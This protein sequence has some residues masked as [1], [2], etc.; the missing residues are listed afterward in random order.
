MT[1]SSSTD[2]MIGDL[3][4]HWKQFCTE[5]GE[6]RGHGVS[7]AA[8]DGLHNLARRAHLLDDTSAFAGIRVR[9]GANRIWRRRPR[10]VGAGRRGGR[11]A[12]SVHLFALSLVEEKRQMFAEGD[13]GP[14]GNFAI[15][16]ELDTVIEG[17]LCH[18]DCVDSV[19]I[20]DAG[21]DACMAKIWNSCTNSR[22]CE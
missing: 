21:V 4:E 1:I 8:I 13:V 3:D 12:L 17:L 16:R 5:P 9:D 11:M 6:R 20:I 18:S 19:Y 15:M 10:A 14:G 2:F 22:L 7:R